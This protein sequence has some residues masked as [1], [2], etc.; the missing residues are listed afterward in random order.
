MM[1]IVEELGRALSLLGRA[2]SLGE[3][4]CVAFMYVD[5]SVLVA[6]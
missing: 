6:Y 1:G 4:W 3:H 5:D 2:L